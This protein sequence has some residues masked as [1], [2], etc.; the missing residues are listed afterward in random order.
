MRLHTPALH[1]HHPPTRCVCFVCRKR[2]FT[3]YFMYVQLQTPK[4]VSAPTRHSTLYTA[5]PY[6]ASYLVCVVSVICFASQV[7]S[8]VYAPVTTC[9]CGHLTMR[10][11]RRRRRPRVHACR[12]GSPA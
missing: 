5:T 3:Y 8:F 9:T 4:T 12:A 2:I 6:R 7:S 10:R 11:M 1:P